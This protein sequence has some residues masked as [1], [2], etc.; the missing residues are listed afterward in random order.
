[1][2]EDGYFDDKFVVWFEGD[3]GSFSDE[4]GGGD[5]A[6]QPEEMAVKLFRVWWRS[7][8]RV[9]ARA[10]GQVCIFDPPP[11]ESRH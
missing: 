2:T 3:C 5:I 4:S 7:K 11:T 9:A 6:S 10:K 1:M 8:Q